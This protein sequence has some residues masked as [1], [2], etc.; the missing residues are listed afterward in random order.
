M[1]KIFA[2][3]SALVLTIAATAQTLNVKVGNVVY[4]YPASQTGMM[5]YSNGNSLTIMDKVFA[6]SDI[7][8]MTVDNSEVENNRVTVEYD[9]SSAKVYVAL[10]MTRLH[11]SCL[12]QLLTALSP[13]PALIN[14]RYHWLA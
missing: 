10:M 6:L 13:F 5:T 8:A 14:A 4:Q 3:I 11:I 12:A 1:K 7:D 9:A 2:L